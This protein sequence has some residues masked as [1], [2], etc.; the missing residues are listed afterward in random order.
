MLS[1][2]GVAPDSTPAW[3][4]TCISTKVQASLG[5]LQPQQLGRV[6]GCSFQS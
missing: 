4:L 5:L 2:V 1:V 3:E 6:E